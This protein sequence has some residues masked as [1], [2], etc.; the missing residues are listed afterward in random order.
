MTKAKEPSEERFAAAAAKCLEAHT[1]P[2]KLSGWEFY[3][4]IGS[5]K[6]IVA[7]MVDQSELAWRILS[8][9][10]NAQLCY[11]PMFNARIFSHEEKYRD[12]HWEGLK[13]GLGGGG[14]NDRPLF[15]QFCANDPEHLLNAALLVAPY[16]DAVDINLGC[17]Q[18]IARRGHYGSFLMEDWPLISSMISTLHKYLPIPVTAKIRVFPEAEKTVAYAKMVVEAG[19][20]VLVVHGRLRE[21][22]GHLTGVADWEKIRLVQEAV[23]HLV[24]VIANGNILYHEDVERCLEKTGCAGVM[25][26][27]GNLY[28]PAIFTPNHPESWRL[29]EE[30]LTI[31]DE[32]DTKI[33]YTRGHL[34]KIFQPCLSIH[35]DL[36]TELGLTNSREAMWEVTRKLKER[37]IKEEEESKQ[38]GESFEGRVNDKG[39]P[40][41]PHWVA[42]PYFRQPMPPQ[43]QKK[44][45]DGEAAALTSTKR[46]AEASGHREDEEHGPI[47]KTKPSKNKKVKV[48]PSICND[49]KCQNS[50]SPK[51]IYQMCKG[52]CRLHQR[53]RDQFDCPSHPI[54]SVRKDKQ[55]LPRVDSQ[56]AIGLV[57]LEGMFVNP[58]DE[59]VVIHHDHGVQQ[60]QEQLEQKQDRC[61]GAIL[62]PERALNHREVKNA[63]PF[64]RKQGL[65]RTSHGKAP[66][67]LTISKIRVDVCLTHNASIRYIYS[68]PTDLNVAHCNSGK[69]RFYIDGIRAAEKR[70][71]HTNRHQ[72]RQKALVKAN[73]AISNPEIRLAEKRRFGNTISA[74]QTYPCS[75][76]SIGQCQPYD[77]VPSR[78]SVLF[79]K[80]V[81]VVWRPMSSYGSLR[82]V[83]YD[84]RAIPEILGLFS[85][86]LVALSIING[87]DYAAN[88]RTE[89]G[90]ALPEE[91]YSN[92]FKVFVNM[93]QDL[94]TL[95]DFVERPQR[96]PPCPTLPCVSGWIA[97]EVF[98]TE[99]YPKEYSLKPWKKSPEKP[100][101]PQ[102]TKAKSA[103]IKPEISKVNGFGRKE[104][105]DAL[106]FE[107]SHC[108]FRP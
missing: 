86:Q 76:L 71:T 31:C 81:P 30:Y 73:S 39:F 25:S 59:E 108:H 44:S 35:T 54:N 51:C 80:S 78:D 17:P 106:S 1:F 20:Q 11:T 34:F 90:H 50:F 13:N 14:P 53:A 40:I 92:A 68:N 100:I 107:R 33:A 46:T 24:P 83:P 37:L 52:C 23:G 49:A 89:N 102:P 87:N 42:Q 18:H 9:R 10:Y 103:A 74:K 75:R 70:Q 66:L 5:P 38:R 12:E 8:R 47:V 15:T 84:E 61:S 91:S 96:V 88:R 41:L 94:A 98:N 95:E 56:E 27:E 6:Y 43:D 104:M 3:K 16:C 36:R 55:R 99:A 58:Q 79:Y 82:F 57:A 32:L 2:P 28:N 72:V 65:V 7:P 45:E 101:A 62:K 64:L 63:W 21:M 19:A 48:A 69:L 22:K 93:E 60:E 97:F 105:M 29:A 67:S 4:S 26:A 85:V 77:A